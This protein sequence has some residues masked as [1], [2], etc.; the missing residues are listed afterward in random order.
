MPKQIGGVVY[1]AM[2]GFIWLELSELIFVTVTCA[3][4]R[5]VALLPF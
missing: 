1:V 2:S 4:G 5:P 3:D